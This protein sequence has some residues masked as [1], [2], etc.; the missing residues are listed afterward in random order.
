MFRR[1]FI[2]N[3]IATG[4]LLSINSC[5]TEQKKTPDTHEVFPLQEMTISGLMTA[6][7]SGELTCESVTRMYL[8]RIEAIDKSGPTLR[9]ILAINPEALTEA[10]QLDEQRKSGKVKGPLHGI[11]VLLKDNIDTAGTMKTTAGSLALKDNQALQNAFITQKLIDAGALIL[12]KTN[13]SE[14]A[15]FR[16]SRSSS[17]WSA[18]GGQTRNPY[19]I[20]R[21]PC[22]SS[23]GSGAAVAANLCAVAVGTETDGS[24]VCPASI[25]GIVGI[26]PTIGLVSRSGIVPIAHSHD[27]AG[28]MTRTVEDAA[29]LLSVLAG[30]DEKDAYTQRSIGKIPSDYTQ[31]LNKDGMRGKRIGIARRFFGFHELV[32]ALLE[33]AIDAMKQLGATL[34]EVPPDELSDLADEDAYTV[35]LY[36]FKHDLKAYLSTCP[37]QVSIRSLEDLIAFNEVNKDKEMPYFQQEVFLEAAKKGEHTDEQYLH[38]LDRVLKANGENGIDKALKTHQLDAIIAPSNGPTWPIDLVTGDHFLGGSSSPAARSG[39]PS[40]TV[41]AG[42]V[43]GLPIGIS[44]FA[45]AFSEPELI[46]MAYAYEQATM[47]RRQPE[48]RLSFNEFQPTEK[49]D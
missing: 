36:E 19:I 2:K 47:H 23:S 21:S 35:L 25:N 30:I 14:W 7:E 32:D 39:Y 18:M 33:K 28:T 29:V 12:G 27:T 43:H 10:R 8:D 3:S 31:F 1:S 34:V 20:D 38:A 6:Y 17:G 4:T 11:P 46:S 45:G 15:N 5:S 49:S 42:H 41:P 44:I 37:E 26:K 16:S 22:G 24:I 13:L 9:S 40:I 48:F